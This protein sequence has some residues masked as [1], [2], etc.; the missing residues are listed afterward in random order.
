MSESGKENN[1]VFA[2]VACGAAHSWEIAVL[3]T[4]SEYVERKAVQAAKAGSSTGFAAFPFIFF[5]KR[6]INQAKT[7][8]YAEMVERYTWIEWFHN[9][10][11]AYQ[12][13]NDVCSV[14]KPF[15]HAIQNE[16][17]LTNLHIIQPKLALNN[18]QVVIIYALSEFGL[19]C[20]GA[21]HKNKEQAEL[22]ALK[23]LY[24]HAIGLFR[25]QSQNM[26]PTTTYDKR[27]AWIS[28][29]YSIL[30]ERLMSQ[31]N[32]AISMPFPVTFQ[33][34]KIDFEETHVVQRCVF[35]GYKKKF[36]SEDNELYV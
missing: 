33:N 31:G 35:E 34:I 27:V 26:Q 5:K 18:P 10:N 32:E 25:M 30:Q 24:M 7:Y 21:A 19:V 3:K 20:G 11:I 17:Q 4:Q 2:S 13:R 8:A 36:I 1:T 29:N 9:R 23:E 14:N 16:M 22:S 15:Y 28:Q 6:A 12:L